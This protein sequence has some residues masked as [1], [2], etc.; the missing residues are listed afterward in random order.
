MHSKQVT[1]YQVYI[2]YNSVQN[3]QGLAGADQLVNECFSFPA[4]RLDEKC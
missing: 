4:Y 3:S 2:C 1:Y